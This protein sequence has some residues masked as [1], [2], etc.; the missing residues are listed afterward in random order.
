MILAGID[1]ENGGGGGIRTHGG[2]A[3][4][5]VF[6]TATIDRSDTPPEIGSAV[7][8]PTR[9]TRLWALYASI[10]PPRNMEPREGFEPPTRGLQNHCATATP[11]RHVKP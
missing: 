11:S 2:L 10:T 7:G 8:N 4:S 5:A 9:I 3:S 6:R 1:A